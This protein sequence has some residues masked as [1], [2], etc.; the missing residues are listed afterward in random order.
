VASNIS[1]AVKL[2]QSEAIFV[3]V[4]DGLGASM[5]S[6]TDYTKYDE[7]ELVEMFGRMD[8]RWTPLDCTRLKE[9]LVERGYVVHDGGVGPGF[10]V[11]SSEKIQ[12]LIG[13]PHPIQCQVMF[14]QTAGLFGWLERSRNALGLF[15]SGT[16]KADGI[17]LRL[18][19]RPAGLL[20]SLFH[21][22]VQLIWRGIVNVESDEN[23]VH[24]V[25][26]DEGSAHK[27]ITLWLPDRAAAERLATVL[28]KVRTPE[29]RSQ[30]KAHVEFERSFIARSAHT[31]A[32]VALVAIN[33]LVFLAT[34]VS[35]PKLIA[36]GS[37]L[38]PYTTDGEWWRLLMSLFLH[39]G[40]FHLLFNMW[41]LASFGPL[42]ERLYGSANYLFL[43]LVAG[44]TGGLVSISWRPEVNSVGASG[45]IFGILGALLAAQ[46]RVGDTFLSD[47]LRPLRIS[48]LIFAGLALLAGFTHTGVD[49]AAHLGG[50]ATG[51]LL[52]AATAHPPPTE[53]RFI[54]SDIRRYTQAIALTVTFVSA[55][56]W[57]ALRASDSLIGEGSY[58][59]T[60]H[61]FQAGEQ[62]ADSRFNAALNLA[63]ADKLSY[64]A[65]A[66]RLESDTLP[67]WREASARIF[68]ISLEPTSPN[69][70]AL[71]L[72][73]TL[74]KNNVHGYE[75]LAE[76]LRKNDPQEIAA[77]E[78]ELKQSKELAEEWQST[79]Q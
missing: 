12:A 59:R 44:V 60:I 40:V 31:P 10:A 62:S 56:V 71:E 9:L 42:A 17:Y 68:E 53:R 23:V 66:D 79:H 11:P 61:W 33:V 5:A 43:Y 34:A 63:R 65:F 22:Q 8:S 29:F 13:S 74:S 64:S 37:N 70:P 19:G 28:P 67:F 52:G 36:A 69:L 57:C 75:L 2:K 78:A 55:G 32:T 38:G 73:Q 58:W 50:L 25:Y 1:A 45:A 18:S 47:S 4:R 41:A 21:R 27:A 77:G 48:T 72:F 51:F 39:L 15:G 6:E 20:G 35:G 3:D 7:S 54:P 30:L 26:R 14:G 16:L 24:F 49:N 76:G 46:W